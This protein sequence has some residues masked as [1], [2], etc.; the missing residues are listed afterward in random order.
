VPSLY[1][2]SQRRLTHLGWALTLEEFFDPERTKTHQGHPSGLDL[3]AE[4]RA[5]LIR[6]IEQW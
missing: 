5:A 6:E 3:G 2:V 1:R 4:R